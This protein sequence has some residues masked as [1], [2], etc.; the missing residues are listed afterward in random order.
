MLDVLRPLKI[1]LELNNRL[2]LSVISDIPQG[3]WVKRP[4]DSANHAAFLALHLIDARCFMLRILGIQTIHGFEDVGKE[5]TCLEDIPE[6]PASEEMAKSWKRVSADLLSSVDGVGPEL[7]NEAAP[8]EFPVNDSSKLGALA[9]L[10]QHEAYHIG[11][12]GI[13]R[14]ILGLSPMSYS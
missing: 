7:L 1:Q 3:L 14:R 11:Q 10:A 12:L 8:H 6:Y 5:A 2:F 4:G 13:V 9:F